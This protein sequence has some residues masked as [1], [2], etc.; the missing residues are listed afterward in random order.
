VWTY[1][2]GGLTL[3]ANKTFD[4][5]DAALASARHAY[6]ELQE[7]SIHLQAATPSKASFRL[8]DLLVGILLL[9]IA[10][11]NRRATRAGF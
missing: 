5:A 6:P 1:A 8:R 11:R 7:E 3:M 2:D 9:V 4:S 10:R